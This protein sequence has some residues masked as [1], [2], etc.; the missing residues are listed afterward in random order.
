VYVVALTAEGYANA[1]IAG[2]VQKII[3][4]T[5]ADSTVETYGGGSSNVSAASNGVTTA[6]GNLSVS[7]STPVVKGAAAYAWYIG[8]SAATAALAAITTINS[9]LITA[10]AAGTQ[11]ANTIIADNSVNALIFDGLTTL[12]CKGNAGYFYSMPTGTNGTGTG[13]TGLNGA[14]VEFEAALK[15]FWDNSRLSPDTIWL[16]AQEVKNLPAKLIVSGGTPIVRLNLDPKTDMVDLTAGITI[17]WYLNRYSMG[18]NTRIK[19][20]L[21]P[22]MPAGTILFTTSSLPYKL[23]GVGNVMQIK[24][25]SSYQMIEWALKT[26]QYEYGVYVNEVLQHYAPFSLGMIVNVADA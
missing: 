4:R 26:R 6:G 10:P 23:S 5:N 16:S 12:C 17:G 3:S 15:S 19:L 8:T 25:R 9:V 14:I 7:A 18:S 1:S 20:R 22:N 13:L 2:G 11:M 21:H 24:E